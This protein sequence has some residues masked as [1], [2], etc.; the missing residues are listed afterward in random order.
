MRASALPLV[1]FRPPISPPHPPPCWHRPA[2]AGLTLLA[3]S[4]ALPLRTGNATVDGVPLRMWVTLIPPSEA[5]DSGVPLRCSVP[6]DSPLTGFNETA[7]FNASLGNRGCLDFVGTCWPRSRQFYHP[8]PPQFPVTA[9]VSWTRV[10]GQ[11]G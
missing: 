6:A 9:V 10:P 2:D 8:A 3:V 5:M 4:L 7:L 11:G 1:A